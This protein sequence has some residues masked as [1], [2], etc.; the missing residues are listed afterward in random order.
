MATLRQNTKLY[1][2]RFSRAGEDVVGYIHGHPGWEL[3]RE[4]PLAVRLPTRNIVKFGSVR[5]ED[6]LFP[7]PVLERGMEDLMTADGKNFQITYSFPLKTRRNVF[8]G[9]TYG[10]PGVTMRQLYDFLCDEYNGGERFI[11]SYFDYIFPSSPAGRFFAEFRAEAARMVNAEYKRLTAARRRRTA[12]TGEADRRT[13]EWRALKDFR[14]WR[15]ELFIS[16]LDMAHK[17]IKREIIQYL[18]IGKIPLRFRPASETIDIRRDRALAVPHGFYASGQLIESLRLSIRIPESA[19]RVTP[20]FE[21]VP[22]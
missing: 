21:E 22:F 11:D 1:E 17:V 5:E 12:R 18:S 16:K 20:G 14:V 2:T 7:D 6:E 3:N 4:Y 10:A 19:F 9:G 15:D 8:A 13:K